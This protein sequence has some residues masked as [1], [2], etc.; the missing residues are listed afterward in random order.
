[1]AQCA[2]KSKRSGKQ[3]RRE[4]TPGKRVCASHGS[5]ST[6]PKTDEGKAVSKYNGVTHGIYVQGFT[7]EDLADLEA[8]HSQTGGK[9]TLEGELDI[10][11]IHL[12]RAWIAAGVSVGMQNPEEGLEVVEQRTSQD[13][14]GEIA[15]RKA[16]VIRKR[17]DMWIIVDKYLRTVARL[18]E[19]Q[20]NQIEVNRA[21]EAF[22]SAEVRMM[23]NGNG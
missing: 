11:R 16:E 13:T 12:K 22:R 15:R 8:F 20:V 4:A 2:A 19:I 21:L 7:R 10:A 14:G 17:P 18:V 1:M 5:K 6:G 23:G 3:C 9:P